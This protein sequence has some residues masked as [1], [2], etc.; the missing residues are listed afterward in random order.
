MKDIYRGPVI[1][2]RI[3]GVTP[4]VDSGAS[5]LGNKR[6]GGLAGTGRSSLTSEATFRPTGC[7]LGG[8][9]YG[10][11]A[12]PD[13][14]S[15]SAPGEGTTL[16]PTRRSAS[17]TTKVLSVA[18]TLLAVS[19][20]AP[21]AKLPDRLPQAVASQFDGALD[22]Q[23]RALVTEVHYPDGSVQQFE[24]RSSASAVLLDVDGTFIT[25]GHD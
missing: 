11:V 21:S 9:N 14:E 25:V 23:E 4:G 2:D 7:S 22:L 18:A 15:V 1:P 3:G 20:C 12:S 24:E 8:E 16:P 13:V 17:R 10:L 5:V 6:A 19:A